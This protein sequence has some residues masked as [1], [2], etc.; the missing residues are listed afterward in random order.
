MYHFK[1]SFNS[2]SDSKKEENKSK[3]RIY[4]T[5]NKPFLHIKSKPKSIIWI[6]NHDVCVL[7][8]RQNFSKK[9]YIKPLTNRNNRF[10][11]LF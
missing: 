7:F 2:Y 8:F 1:G 4:F 3:K 10:N 11:L 6:L 9:C 5:L